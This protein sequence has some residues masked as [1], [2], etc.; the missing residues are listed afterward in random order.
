MRSIKKAAALSVLSIALP[1][2]SCG[3]VGF[4]SPE[5]VKTLRVLAVQKD[6]PYAHPGDKVSL[7]MLYWDGKAEEGSPRDVQI[8]FSDCVNPPADLYYRCFS[9]NSTLAPP[10][11]PTGAP[12]PDADHVAL[13]TF[14]LPPDIVSSRPPA[15]GTHAYGLGYVLFTVCAGKVGPVPQA[16]QTSL[17][18]GCF[19]A[20]GSKLGVDD[21]D[22]GYTSIY[23]YDDGRTNAN[24]VIHGFTLRNPEISLEPDADGV[25]HIAR[26]IPGACPKLEFKV[27]IDRASAE[28][29]PGASDLD[30]RPVSEQLWISYY[31]T[32]GDIEKSQRLVNDATRGWNDD[33]ATTWTP[34]PVPGM[35]R[36]WGIV[37]DNRG[38]V[39]WVEAKIS[40]E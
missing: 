21:F 40:V 24:P 26:C 15:P 18:L 1:L 27:D 32:R 36:L 28:P 13:H 10:D 34:P 7:R 4:D 8:F 23:A 39:E 3:G 33:N 31:K 17:P 22:P 6:T 12:M 37:H 38:G 29:D 14:T 19:A 20:D 9:P 30:G 11:P 2:G 25:R 35:A 5:L 16:G